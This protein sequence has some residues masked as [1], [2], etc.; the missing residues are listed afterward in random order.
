M[1][2]LKVSNMSASA[3]GT[4]G[5]PGKNI[6]AKSGLNKSILDQGWFE[7]RRQIEYK[8]NWRGGKLI[9]VPPQYTSQSCSSCGYVSKDNRTSQ[10]RFVCVACS[11]AQNA[12]LNAALNILA[13][14]HAVLACGDIKRIAT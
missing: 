12:D 6:K 4:V 5:D 9:L 13:A 11:H 7:F 2:N 8:L 14:G 3:K 1:E 10:S